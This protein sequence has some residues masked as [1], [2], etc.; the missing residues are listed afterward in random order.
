MAW[1]F[2]S[3]QLFPSR[4]WLMSAFG[5][6]IWMP[7]AAGYP[8]RPMPEV[9]GTETLNFVEKCHLKAGLFGAII[10]DD[11]APAKEGS[12]AASGRL[13]F[14]ESL[15]QSLRLSAHLQI[16]KVRAHLNFE[17]TRML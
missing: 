4:Q 14:R 11:Q 1:V 2:I 13:I 16:K 8:S 3:G 5:P 6:R 17:I 7:Q 15:R 10:V 9:K 12:R